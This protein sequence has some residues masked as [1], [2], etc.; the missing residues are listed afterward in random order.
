MTARPQEPQRRHPS[1]AAAEGGPDDPEVEARAADRVIVFS[2]AVIAIAITLLALALPVP[3]TSNATTNAQLLDKL[4][5]DWG[6]YLAFLVSFL[7]IGGNWSAH[8]RTF[9]YVSRLN[10]QVGRLNMLWL[11]MMILT[12]ARRLLAASGAFGARFTIYALIQVI[13]SACLIQI[14][15]QISRDDLLRADAPAAARH[16][17][18]NHDLALIALFLVAIPVAFAINSAWTFALLALVRPLSRI[19]QWYMTSGRHT[20]NDPDRTIR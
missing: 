12:P 7:I 11:L 10:R 14:G 19:P 8:R 20:A 16:P 5:G 2:D 1:V 6:D 3:D 13:A 18:N 4:G 9:R 17:D 15:R